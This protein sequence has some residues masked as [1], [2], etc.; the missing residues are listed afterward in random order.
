[1]QLFENNTE[2][3]RLASALDGERVR[4]TRLRLQVTVSWYLRQRDNPRAAQL[5][6][7]AMDLLDAQPQT[8]ISR[9]LTARLLL[10][11]SETRWL[12]SDF[13]GAVNAAQKALRIF[14]ELN[15]PVGCADSFSALAS[16]HTTSGDLSQRDSSLSSAVDCA[17]QAQDQQ[18]IDYY[19]ANQARYATLRNVLESIAQWRSRFTEEVAHMPPAV[20]A[21]VYAFFAVRNYNTGNFGGA[22]EQLNLSYEAAC[23]SGQILTAVVAAVNAGGTYVVLN[24][25]DAAL[26]WLQRGLDLARP[27]GWAVT[28]G[29]CLRQMGEV[30][31]AMGRLEAAQSML[32]EALLVYQPLRNSRNFTMVLTA[33]GDLAHTRGDYPRALACYQQQSSR[34]QQLGQT[35]SAMEGNLGIANA[36]LQLGQDQEA[37]SSAIAAL[38]MARSQ[39]AATHEVSALR[40]LASIHAG[41]GDHPG[42]TVFLEQAL[43]TARKIDGYLIPSDLLFS[44]AQEYAHAQRHAEAYAISVEANAAR[45]RVLNQQASNRATAIQVRLGTERSRAEGE[46]HRRQA[47]AETKRAELLQQSSDTL[48]LLGTIGQEITSQL[49]KEHVFAA[50][51]HHVHGLL[52]ASSF[53]IYLMDADQQGMTSVYDIEEGVRLVSDHVRLDDESSFSARCVRER[54]ELL[55]DFNNPALEPNYVPGTLPTVSA[56]FAPL[57]IAQRVL[58]VMTIQSTRTNAYAENER[59]IFRTLCAYTAIALDNAVAYTHLRDAK[60]QLV[61]QEKLAALG[62]LV[63]GVAHELNTPIGNSLLTASTLQENT[64]TLAVAATSGTLR[65]STL[66]D[67]IAACNEGLELVVRGLRSAADLV[68]S[69]KQVAVDRATEQRRPFEL[70]R[71]S[72]EVIAT[73]QRNIQVSGHRLLVN[74][75]QGITLDGYPGPYGQVLTNLIN[76][77]MVHAFGSRKG[78]IMQLEAQLL[79]NNQVELRFSDDGIGIATENL[80]R[81]FD[82]FFTTKLGQGG[83]GLGMSI[84]YNIVT[85]LFGGTFEVSSKPGAGTCFVLRVPLSAPQHASNNPFVHPA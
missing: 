46:R 10:V 45:E 5:A 26:E 21:S 33:L 23:Q 64:A 12:M 27:T 48:S 4:D 57:T 25:H 58:G 42:A 70:L 3:D 15:D 55:I 50:I 36:L 29:P 54:K 16:V 41:K 24:D 82:P 22:L 34:A 6:S 11:D 85:S 71:T 31:R 72:Q 60:D 73:M 14:G 8:E 56:L 2:V 40:L 78:G 84:S 81:I 37:M 51:E 20:S 67:Y 79:R 75:P 52:D 80:P 49:D 7:Q 19:E 9:A 28:L 66:T 35:D 62:S 68:Q 39:G 61:V 59:L 30:M 44:L 38:G 63:A 65:R 18:R 43:E 76:N 17:R 47:E 53:A 83:S 13:E 32:D 77:A 69:F 74:I 1:M